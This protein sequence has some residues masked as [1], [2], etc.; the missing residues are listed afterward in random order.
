M[1]FFHLT[2]M[3]GGLSLFLYGMSEMGDGLSTMAGSKME[4]ILER[5]TSKRIFA[6]LLG[7]GV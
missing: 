2:K 3:L 4:R 6:V 1:D 5:L 7:L